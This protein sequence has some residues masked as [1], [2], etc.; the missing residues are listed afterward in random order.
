MQMTLRYRAD[1]TCEILFFLIVELY[2]YF[3]ISLPLNK[4]A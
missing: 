2:V 3:L 1:M 4:E